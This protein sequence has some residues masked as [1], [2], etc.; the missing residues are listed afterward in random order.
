MTVFLRKALRER[1]WRRAHRRCEYCQ[2]PCDASSIPSE[3]DHIISQKHGGKTVAD[4]LALSCYFC[5]SFKGPNIAG[6][7]PV[8]DEVVRLFRPRSD[9]WHE[10]FEWHGAVLIARTS[11]GRATIA[12]MEI[13]HPA[14]IEVREALIAEGN[15]P[16]I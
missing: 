15:F 2:L 9:L 1:V 13:N 10:H 12:V 14:S 16:P 7:D 5:N 3:I 4:N 11:I 8:S 6:I